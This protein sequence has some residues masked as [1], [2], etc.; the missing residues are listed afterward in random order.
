[1][2][3]SSSFLKN[4]SKTLQ[5]NISSFLLAFLVGITK[6]KIC[7]LP[8]NPVYEYEQVDENFREITI[9]VHLHN[10]VCTTVWATQSLP[11]HPLTPSETFSL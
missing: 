9:T 5:N 10:L 7:P 6:N 4:L 2:L 1:M 11:E 3:S 8:Q